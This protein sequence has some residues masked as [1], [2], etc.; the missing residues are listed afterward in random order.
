[1]IA[2][3]QYKNSRLNINYLKRVAAPDDNGCLMWMGGKNER[4]YG[5]FRVG[6][7]IWMA[8]RASFLIHCGDIPDG[9]LVCHVCDNSLCVNPDHLF[10]GTY[11]DNMLDMHKKGR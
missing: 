2:R 7:K 3:D 10:V 8:H 6:K 11:Q 5:K 1:M 9:K 4:N